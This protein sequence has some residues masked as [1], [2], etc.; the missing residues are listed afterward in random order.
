MMEAGVKVLNQVTEA[1]DLSP[2]QS[3]VTL[4]LLATPLDPS[5]SQSS[6]E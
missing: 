3:T 4:G 1:R 2:R 5:G 6:K